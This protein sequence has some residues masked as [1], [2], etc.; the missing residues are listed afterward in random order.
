[1]HKLRQR[2]GK[3]RKIALREMRQRNP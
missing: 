3:K 2:N 1:M